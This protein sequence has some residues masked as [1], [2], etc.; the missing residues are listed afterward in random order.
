M[1]IA[2]V[3]L[4]NHLILCHPLLLPPI[5]P[6]IKVL[7]NEL[8][9]TSRGQSIA[10]APILQLGK[11]RPRERTVKVSL[12]QNTESQGCLVPGSQLT[13]SKDWRGLVSS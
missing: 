3:M 10:A 13:L 6:S 8:G 11:E 4:S 5:F 12:W 7:S 1:S 2:L 9:F